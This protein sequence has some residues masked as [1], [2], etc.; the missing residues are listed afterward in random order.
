VGAAAQQS[1]TADSCSRRASACPMGQTQPLSRPSD[2]EAITDPWPAA[3]TTP[4]NQVLEV[5]RLLCQC[6]HYQTQFFPADFERGFNVRRKGG[7][8]FTFLGGFATAAPGLGC[9]VA[10]GRRLA[11]IAARK[12][13][14][15]CPA[16][17]PGKLVLL[18]VRLQCL[19]QTCAFCSD[20][21]SWT[22]KYRTDSRSY[23]KLL[24]GPLF[25]GWTFN[26]FNKGGQCLAVGRKSSTNLD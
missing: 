25:R 21:P 18:A 4:G 23:C 20:F 10:N 19:L 11:P 16:A 7:T 17:P 9:A 1:S 6:S 12:S 24:P 26:G 5:C 22:R 2:I 3:P 13:R 8:T 14:R 15:L